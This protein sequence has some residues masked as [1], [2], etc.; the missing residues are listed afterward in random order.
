MFPIDFRFYLGELHHVGRVP[1]FL[2]LFG[3]WI[4][5]IKVQ[6]AVSD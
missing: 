5:V 1:P 3:F 4:T 6:A 2:P